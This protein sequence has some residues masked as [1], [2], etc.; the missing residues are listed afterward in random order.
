MLWDRDEIPSP[1]KA[2]NHPPPHGA[3]GPWEPF[4]VS[5]GPDRALVNPGSTLQDFLPL[6]TPGIT[7]SPEGVHRDQISKQT[8]P[9]HPWSVV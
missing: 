1:G 2:P 8:H 7:E 5:H 6:A 9:V 4:V 3:A